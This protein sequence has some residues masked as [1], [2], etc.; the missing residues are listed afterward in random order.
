MHRQW[1][2]L[3]RPQDQT[4]RA[5]R[6]RRL[7]LVGQHTRDPGGGNRRRDR[8][9]RRVDRQARA[10]RHRHRGLAGRE[11]PEIGRIETLEHDAIM[12]LKARRRLWRTTRVQI[13]RACARHPT[14]R[15]D[16]GCH[17]KAVGQRPDPHRYV[18]MLINQIDDMIGQQEPRGDVGIGG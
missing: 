16:P 18:D 15:A 7:D 2:G 13:T 9:I 3:V 4:Q 1:L 14:Y 5:G 17:Q 10:D 8:R 6:D 11:T 12:P